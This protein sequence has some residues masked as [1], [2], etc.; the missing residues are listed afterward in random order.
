MRIDYNELFTE[1]L[2]DESAYHLIQ[3]FYNF[4]LIFDA[5]HSVKAMRHK[6]VIM[7]AHNPCAEFLEEDESEPPF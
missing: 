7:Q 5:M 1:K 4:A 2:S 6:K 3:F